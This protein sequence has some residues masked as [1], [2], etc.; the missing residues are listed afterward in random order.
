MAERWKTSI[1]SVYNLG[2]HIIWCPKYRRKVLKDDIATRLKILLYEKSEERGWK[3]EQMEVMED[4]VH[5]FIK[6]TP[7]DSIAFVVAQLKGYSSHELRKDYPELWRR[8]PNLWT[9]S[10][11]VESCGC[12]SEDKIKKYI[13]NQKF[14]SSHD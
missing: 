13:E 8:L 1:T 6:I 12:M 7:V 14:N 3:I 9:R 2:F 11:Y 10:Y 5:L 4:H